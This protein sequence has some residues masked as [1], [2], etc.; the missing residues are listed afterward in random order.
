MNQ[1]FE[2]ALPLLKKIE[3]HGFEAVFVGGSVRDDIL[4]RDI[5][6]VDI[7]TSATPEEIKAIFPK[8]INVGIQHGTVMVLEQGQ[9]YEITT[10][11]VESEYIDYRKP[12]EVRFIRSLKDDLQ[13]RDFTMNA[14]A[15]NANGR[16][17]DPFNGQKDIEN[18][19]IQT[20]GNP[21]D[22]FTEDALRMMRALRFV[23]QLSFTCSEQVIKALSD[24]KSLLENIS[25]ERITMEFEK[26]LKGSKVQLAIQL[27]IETGLFAYLPGCKEK[28]NQLKIISEYDLSKLKTLNEKWA[29]IMSILIDT[30]EVESFLR[31]WKLPIKQ[32]R[33]IKSIVNV[34]NRNQF[35]NKMEIFESGIECI[36]SAIR[37]Q[38]LLQHEIPENQI[39]K[40]K[41]IWSS[42]PIYNRSQLAISGTDLM[43]WT[44]KTK[45][46]WIKEALQIIIEK[47]LNEEIANEKEAIHL[48]VQRCNLI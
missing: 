47:V 38:C 2:E 32:I 34:I 26:L 21:N 5:H 18:G 41:S 31:L 11:R 7:A 6:D 45:G 37:V 22:R 8:T 29:M 20:V 25:V 17:I 16:I 35:T 14:I 28:L 4:H 30:D 15:M 9:S 43:Q 46:P 24:N 1:L 48:E 27:L 23:S 13:R 44:T 39:Q 33:D 3:Q 40:S 19:I 42:L 12:K 10:Y 36:I